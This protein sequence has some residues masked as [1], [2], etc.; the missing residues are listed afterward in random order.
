MPNHTSARENT[1][2]HMDTQIVWLREGV[3]ARACAI[4]E[5]GVPN[6]SVHGKSV[7]GFVS[8]KQRACSPEQ[9]VCL[10]S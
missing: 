2:T 5:S 7:L 1:K 4:V 6:K 3:R 8:F 10:K 9:S